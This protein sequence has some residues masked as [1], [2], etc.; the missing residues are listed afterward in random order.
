MSGGRGVGDLGIRCRRCGDCCRAVR[1][2]VTHFDLA[3]LVQATGLEPSAVVE[4]LAPEEI[5][6]T[7]EPETFVRLRAGRRLM[8][9]RHRDGGCVFLDRDRCV[10]HAV[11][12]LPCALYPFVLEEPPERPLVVSRLEAAGCEW[13][14]SPEPGP[15]VEV[16]RALRD[17]LRA[18]AALVV[19]WNRR[20]RLRAHLARCAEGEAQFFALL[21][22]S[23]PAGSSAALR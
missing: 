1:V 23:L 12:P 5:D 14:P 20:Q 17:E 8:V 6:M 3:R 11:R 4:W 10:A 9:L 18:Y 21:Q 15:L 16:S 22:R 2:P 19:T 13:A 7:G